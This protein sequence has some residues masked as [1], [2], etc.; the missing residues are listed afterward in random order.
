M[1]L[2]APFAGTLE[3]RVEEGEIVTQTQVIAWIAVKDH[4][5]LRPLISPSRG[6]VC[7]RRSE[8]LT[9]VEAGDPVALL[10]EDP[11]ART[12]CLA[13]ERQAAQLLLAQLRR[14]RSALEERVASTLRRELLRGEVA[15][16][17]LRI[18]RIRQRWP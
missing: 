7:W 17:D 9:I 8:E 16:A 10:R 1:P 14:D 15:G 2:T 12:E 18:A 4:C 3:W 5:A 13:S 11:Q 6:R